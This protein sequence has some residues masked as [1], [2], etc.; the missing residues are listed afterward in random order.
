MRGGSEIV[1][2]ERLPADGRDHLDLDT[3]EVFQEHNH[4]RLHKG[5]IKKE[6]NLI[7]ASIALR[8]FPV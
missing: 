2:F 3:S 5:C 4:G 1:S 8:A 6:Q 7:C